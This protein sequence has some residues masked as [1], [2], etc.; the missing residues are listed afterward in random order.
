MIIFSQFLAGEYFANTA[1]CDKIITFFN[2]CTDE[3][4]QA[5][6]MY[7]GLD[8]DKKDSTDFTLDYEPD[9]LQEYFKELRNIVDAYKK[10]Y[11]F[12]N[13]YCPW[14]VVES[15][16][17]QHYA[18]GGGYHVWH[19]ERGGPDTSIPSMYQTGSSRH[20]VYMTYLNDVT[21][22]GETHW[23]HQRVKIQPRKGLTIIWPADWTFTHRGLASFTQD[24]YIVTGWLNY[25]N[26]PEKTT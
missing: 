22:G 15:T 9:L 20:L 26:M 13:N 2:N 12:C 25:V 19:T 8:K 24:K 11:P 1:I 5:G 3:R 14:G 18:P 7:E 16:N 6:E 23:A 21:E 17:I 4:K 10:E